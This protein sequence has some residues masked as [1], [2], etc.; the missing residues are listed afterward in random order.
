MKGK[1]IISN[2]SSKYKS[3]I[4][5]PVKESLEG[6]PLIS[7]GKE[8]GFYVKLSDSGSHKIVGEKKEI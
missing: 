3:S 7:Q 2:S 6:I 8:L 5:A 1:G 4:C